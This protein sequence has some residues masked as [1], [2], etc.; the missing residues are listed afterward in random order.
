MKNLSFFS[1]ILLSVCGVSAQS[2]WSI[3]TN[4]GIASEQ[5]L[6]D[7][8]LR[9]STKTSRHF[10]KW[11]AFAQVGTFQMLQSNEAWTGN[12]AY[13]NKRSLSTTNLDLGAGYALLNTTKVR[14]GVEAGGSYRAGRQLW[15]ERSVIINGLQQ[16]YYTLEK[17][18]EVGYMLG[19]NVSF[20]A[21]SRLWIGVD[22]HC[23]SY[24]LF[25]EYLGA[26]LGVAICL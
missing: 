14:F 1:F 5:N 2:N 21:N 10:G 7:L 16:D 23:H 26:G 4:L 6:G 20:R 3:S 17:L 15:P 12:D 24:N 9:L 25:G 19:L 8:G 22:T 13:K 11:S 18:K